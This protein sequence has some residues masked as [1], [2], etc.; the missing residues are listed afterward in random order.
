MTAMWRAGP[1]ARGGR[2][3]SLRGLSLTGALPTSWGPS[4]W[5]SSLRATHPPA[6]ASSAG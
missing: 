6:R 4:P 1:A 2:V 5:G 3:L